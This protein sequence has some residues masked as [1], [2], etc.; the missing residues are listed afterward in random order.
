MVMKCGNFTLE[1]L[2]IR[3]DMNL[4]KEDALQCRGLL[5]RSH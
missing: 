4:I 5:I 2:V 1:P 3:C